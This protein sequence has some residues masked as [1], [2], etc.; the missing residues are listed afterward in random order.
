MTKINKIFI[1]LILFSFLLFTFTPEINISA[2]SDQL[3][4]RAVD[5]FLHES[6]KANRIPGLAV[7]I[8][9]EDEIIFNKGYGE[10]SPGISVTPQTQFYIG[11]VSKS[12]TAQAVM[13]LVEQGK[14]DLDVPVQKYLPWFTVADDK[15]SSTITIRHLLN[16]TSGLSE[17]GDPNAFIYT[18]SLEEQA[19]LLKD[20]RSFAPAGTRYRYYSQNYRLLGLIIEEVSGQPYGQF[21]QEQ[22]FNPLGMPHTVAAPSQAPHLAQ[23]YTRFFGFPIPCEQVFIPGA[24][25]SGYLISTAGDL[26]HFIIAQINNLQIDGSQMLSDDSLK[27]MRSKPGGIETEYGMGWLVMD[28]GNTFAHGGANEYFQSFILFNPQKKTGLVLLFNQNSLENMFFENN[29][30]RDGLLNLMDHKTVRQ[31]YYAWI[32]LLLFVLAAADLVNHIRLFLNVPHCERDLSRHHL[33]WP[34]TK[35]L[36]GII[37]PAA[38]IFGVPF[39]ASA[40]QGGAPTWD[41]PFSLMP[42]IT[43]W[44]LIGSGLTLVRNLLLLPAFLKRLA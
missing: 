4:L 11:S 23:G 26:A 16:H 28:D 44:L 1:A 10:A 24:L 38:I 15:A 7:A 18:A 8:V 42:D 39:I 20:V 29:A 27:Q 9:Q 17:S 40:S 34:I 2:Q 3:D 33:A 19:R 14:L 43:A 25:P 37:I 22:I 36:A 6:T 31:S 30:V 35:V 5:T 32:G 13:R 41:K 21:L 12:F